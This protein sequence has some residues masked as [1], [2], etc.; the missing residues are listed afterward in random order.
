MK[1]AN[2]ITFYVVLLRSHT[3]P[4]PNHNGHNHISENRHESKDANEH[5]KKY[6]HRRVLAFVHR[7]DGVIQLETLLQIIVRRVIRICPLVPGS[8]VAGVAVLWCVH[9]WYLEVAGVMKDLNIPRPY[10]KDAIETNRNIALARAAESV[11]HCYW[12]GMSQNKITHLIRRNIGIL[13]ELFHNTPAIPLSYN[14]MTHRQSLHWHRLRTKRGFVINY[15]CLVIRT[16]GFC[17]PHPSVI[18]HIYK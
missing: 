2:V 10:T 8:H 5:S 11:L 9:G 3:F 12:P 15:V 4:L 13:S 1:R 17:S 7:I 16:Q 18:L 6:C 14:L